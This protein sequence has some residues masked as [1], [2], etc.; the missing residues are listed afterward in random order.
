MISADID[1]E[2]SSIKIFNYIGVKRFE[3][4]EAK[5]INWTL[6]FSDGCGS[7]SIDNW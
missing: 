3:S 6:T 5:Q 4:R 7:F 1:N 2:Y